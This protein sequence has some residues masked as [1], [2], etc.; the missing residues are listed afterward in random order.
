MVSY[1]VNQVNFKL[2]GVE[3]LLPPEAV[4][5]KL[6]SISTGHCMT[7]NSGALQRTELAEYPS[8]CQ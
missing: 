8:Q 5:G 2:E 4:S 3:K 7:G 1:L 6:R